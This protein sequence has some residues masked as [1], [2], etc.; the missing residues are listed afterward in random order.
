VN[1]L[2]IEGMARVGEG[3]PFVVLNPGEAPPAAARFLEYIKSPLLT[4]VEV[5]TPGLQS[6]DLEP[7]RTP[8]LFSTR[9]REKRLIA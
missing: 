4:H 2:L 3:E 7:A 1:R 6:Y 9:S 8:D 5:R